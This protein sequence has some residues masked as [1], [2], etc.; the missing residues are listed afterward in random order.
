[1]GKNRVAGKF[2]QGSGH[3]TDE[4]FVLHEHPGPLPGSDIDGL[5]SLLARWRALIE[6]EVELEGGALTRLRIEPDVAAGLAHDSIDRGQPEPGPEADVLG[7]EE[8]FEHVLT[9]GSIHTDSGVADCQLD[10]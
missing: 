8:R 2:E 4:R 6:R 9:S 10:I 7:R 1:M 3:P 5:R